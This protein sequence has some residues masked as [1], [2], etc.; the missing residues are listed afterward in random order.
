MYIQGY[1]L[2]EQATVKIGLHFPKI[3]F[4]IALAIKHFPVSAVGYSPL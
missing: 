4:S 2:S 3:P 1:I